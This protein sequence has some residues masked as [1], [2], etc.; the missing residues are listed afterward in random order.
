M[1]QSSARALARPTGSERAP[2]RELRLTVEPQ[3]QSRTAME[4]VSSHRSLSYSRWSYDSYLSQCAKH[5]VVLFCIPL[6]N[7]EM[8]YYLIDALLNKYVT[9]VT[10]SP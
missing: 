5:R 8:E 9:D 2:S 3:S 1:V 10:S 4:G 6:V 7:D